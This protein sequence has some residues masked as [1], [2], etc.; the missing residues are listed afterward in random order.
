MNLKF[1]AS[2]RWVGFIAFALVLAVVCVVLAQWQFSRYETRVS[3]TEQAEAAL[4]ADPVPLD[5][6]AGPGVD[7]DASAEWT[8]VVATGQYDVDNQV[9]VKFMHR[10]SA[11]GVD[12]V[13]PLILDNGDAILVNRGWMQTQNN[14]SAPENIPDPPTGTVTVEGWLR[15]NNEAGGQAVRPV[16]EQVR[17]IDSRAMAEFVP[18][19]L[20]S[21]YLNLQEQY[22]GGTGELL[23]EPA[24]QF[25][26]W[27]N[28]FYG[29]QWY[30]FGGLAL[31]G[32]IWF[33]RAELKERAKLADQ[34]K[35]T[36]SR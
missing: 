6:V 18:Y 15:V 1:L 21:G 10:D 5:S 29:I 2:K 17:A 19:D 34:A 24:P 8:R 23:T 7:W 11:P 32:I 22:P 20:R 28:F 31:F 33:A 3:N 4:Q 25:R 13:T 26:S 30:F 14:V 12:V 35:L 16:D 27:V 9:T 36:R